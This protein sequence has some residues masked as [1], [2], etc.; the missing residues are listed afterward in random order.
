M[1]EEATASVP[2]ASAG[3]VSETGKLPEHE[4]TARAGGG[5]RRR[6]ED[7]L[8]R[9]RRARNRAESELVR[10]SFLAEV[11][12]VLASSFDYETTLAR[13]ARLAVSFLAD[14]CAFDLVE[15]DGLRRVVVAHADATKEPIIRELDRFPPDRTWPDDPVL[16]ALDT[17][18]AQ[19]VV[20]GAAHAP[21]PAKRSPEYARLIHW[22]APKSALFAPMLGPE[23]AL[24]VMT[25]VSSD[26]GRTYGREDLAFALDLAGR[27]ALAISNAQLYHEARQATRA[28]DEVLAV[29]AHDLRN[30]IGAVLNGTELLLELEPTAR[31]RHFLEVVHS[32]AR[33]TLRIIDELLDV[34]R[35]D[36]RRIEPSLSWSSV[37]TL[38]DEAIALLGPLAEAR[39]IALAA[40]YT[41]TDVPVLADESIILRVFSN[42]IGNAIKHTPSGG[43]IVVQAA[44][45]TS[46]VV[47][48]V[49]DTGPGIAADQLPHIFGRF[50]Q[51]RA[52][53]R[54]GLGL[55]LAIAKG[56]VEAHG[57]RIWAESP[58]GRGARFHFTVARKIP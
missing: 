30:P 19:L 1:R 22:L 38:V 7:R 28:R 24:G 33:S 25:L 32:S 47:F 8:V 55:G 26:P 4:A 45:T 49:M 44:A 13:V 40:E 20:R 21:D 48:T 37:H 2:T 10:A 17:G 16:R 42:L 35:I 52:G 5:P 12:R 41:A 3:R 29:V 9:E 36:A 34:T 56:L 50:W 43:R 39:G 54:D 23:G 11:S 14:Y 51:G 46:E 57:G 53:D 27:T 6:A 31:Q 15:G 58:P 18:R